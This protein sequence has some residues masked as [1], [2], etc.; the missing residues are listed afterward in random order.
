[1]KEALGLLGVAVSIAIYIP[2]IRDIIRRK[3]TPHP[4]SWLVWG[5]TTSISV[6]LLLSQGAGPGAWPA[7]AAAIICFTVMTLSLIY[8]GHQH[9]RRIDTVMLVAAGG[10]LALWTLAHEPLYAAL[11]LVTTEILGAIPTLRKGWQQPRTETLSLWALSI[12]RH[13]ISF[14][15]LATY[16]FITVLT[17]VVW[18]AINGSMTAVL[19]YRRGK[20]HDRT[21]NTATTRRPSARNRR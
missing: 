19:L 9:I 18:V 20:V 17:P 10:A 3:T 14:S 13:I 7:I 6:G 8:E 21:R 11:L 12:V 2:Y 15:A 5:V 4:Y 1:M 16:T